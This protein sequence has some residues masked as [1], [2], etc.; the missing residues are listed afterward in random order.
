M[1]IGLISDT[2]DNLPL[3]R[4]ACARLVE[5]GAQALIHAGDFVAPFSARIL[6]E[7]GL[8]LRAVLGNN[9]GEVEGLSGLMPGIPRG[10]TAFEM[11]GRS[12]TLI[13]DLAALD[14]V[15]PGCE[16]VVHGHTHKVEISRQG[17][18]LY[19]NPGEACGWLTN[20]A[21]VVLL[22]TDTLGATVEDI[23]A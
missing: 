8:P 11:G 1:L 12:F 19:V 20:R 15:G 23:K 21:T 10:P 6:V 16:I 22:D 3:V 14:D 4:R 13:H 9:D 7:T 5:S 18:I 2:H 17:G